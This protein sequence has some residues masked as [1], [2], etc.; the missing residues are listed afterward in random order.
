MPFGPT[1]T[2]IRS[3]AQY[4]TGSF[5]SRIAIIDGENVPAMAEKKPLLFVANHWAGAVDPAM[6][7]AWLPKQHK[8][9]Y[10][11]KSTLFKHKAVASILLDAGNIP[12]D[13]TNK[14]NQSLFAS[15]FDMFKLAECV[16]I[17]PEGTS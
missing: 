13:R 3:L 17:F 9:H 10:W 15:T 12:V 4:A 16:A 1:H 2:A 6:L 5:F 11:A 7:S 8:L 14:D